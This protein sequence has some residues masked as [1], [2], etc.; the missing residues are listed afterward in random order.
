MIKILDQINIIVGLATV[1]VCGLIAHPLQTA[2][3]NLSKNVDR[4]TQKI[5]ENNLQIT[6]LRERVAKTE[7][8]TNS[9][10]KRIDGIAD[11]L[12]T[13]EHKCEGE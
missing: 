8:S 9:A 2:I 3:N 5:D 1:V 12:L 4:L 6:I 10:H 13:V 11:R 7:N